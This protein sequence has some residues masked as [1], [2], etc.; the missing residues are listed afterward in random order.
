M[1]YFTPEL[2][3]AYN[4]SDDKIAQDA[5]TQWENALLAYREQLTTLT[6]Y[7]DVTSLVS[8][9]LHD[10]RMQ[11]W[12]LI[13]DSLTARLSASFLHPQTQINILY[14]CIAVSW[15]PAPEEWLQ[16]FDGIVGSGDVVIYDEVGVGQ[17]GYIHS[18]LMGDGKV[19]EI[20]FN[21]C[22]VRQVAL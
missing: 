17:H 14:T 6:C 16:A 22:Q 2:L 12:D 4:S 9:D 3:M 7:E 1:H 11:E 15:F 20:H 13:T 5:D 8:L 10:V 21:S 19:C 18:L